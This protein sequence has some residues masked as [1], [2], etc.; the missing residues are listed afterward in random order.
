M[1]I[2][3]RIKQLRESRG[4]TPY[5]LANRARLPLGTVQKI[6]SDVTDPSPGRLALISIALGVPIEDLEPD[7]WFDDDENPALRTRSGDS[8]TRQR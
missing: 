4:L 3:E 6:E 5:Q 2:G 1:T 8:T 7:A